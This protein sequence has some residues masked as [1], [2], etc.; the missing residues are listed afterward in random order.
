MIFYIKHTILS[1]QNSA[2][3]LQLVSKSQYQKE[4]LLN[5]TL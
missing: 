2:K 5:M 4:M 1:A 3:K